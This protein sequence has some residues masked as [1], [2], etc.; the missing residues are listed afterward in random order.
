MLDDEL[1][2]T[3]EG[4]DGKFQLLASVRR[5]AR[6]LHPRKG[7]RKRKRGEERSSRSHPRTFRF[8]GRCTFLRFRC[9]A[10]SL[11]PTE[12]EEMKESWAEFEGDGDRE[13]TQNGLEQMN[14]P[15]A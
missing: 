8:Q 5:D 3:A 2:T 11:L 12:E 13:T 7:K 15:G 9:V 4:K 14:G 10:R 1:D 6:E